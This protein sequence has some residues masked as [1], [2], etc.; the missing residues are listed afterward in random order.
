MQSVNSYLF[1]K[2]KSIIPRI[3][4]TELIALR[5]GTTSLDKE[6]FQGKVTNPIVVPVKYK[7][8]EE[9]IEQLIKKQNELRLNRYIHNFLSKDIMIKY[10][11]LHDLL[12]LDNYNKNEQEQ[13]K[14]KYNKVIQVGEVINP[15]IGETN[16][17]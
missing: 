12:S 1:R 2:V 9:N 8:P 14:Q 10:T 16:S 5:S 7:F 15:G 3:S 6:I 17:G 4:E 13:Y 11:P